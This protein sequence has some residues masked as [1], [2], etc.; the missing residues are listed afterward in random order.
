MHPVI[1]ISAMYENGGNTTHRFLDGHPEL[2]TY[3]FESQLGNDRCHD[4]LS[5]LFPFRYR[6]PDF[7]TSLTTSELYEAFFD[8]E[9]KVRLRS[10]HVSKF[11][12]VRMDLKEADR[13]ALFVKLLDG[14]SLCRSSII[15]AFFQATFQAWK[16]YP[17]SGR[18]RAFLGYSPIIGVDGEKILSDFPDGHVIHVVRNPYSAYADTIKRPFPQSLFRY[19]TTWSVVQLYALT[20]AGRMPDRFHILRFEDLIASP[21]AAMRK[22]AQRIK[23]PFQE[24]MLYPSWC[25][26][27]L[28]EVYPWGTIRTPTPDANLATMNELAREQREQ[29]RSLT[30]PMLKALD[31]HSL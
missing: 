24:T 31:Y 14:R 13:K 21:E 25:G 2:Y 6:W 1:M 15:A 28:H 4:H 10:P 11:R 30:E 5:S 3:P 19:A 20:F 18:E 23:L 29:I 26:A 27:K 17:R 9:L 8:E 16:D 22:L 7:P 12:D